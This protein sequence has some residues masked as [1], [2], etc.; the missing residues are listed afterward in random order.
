[1]HFYQNSAKFRTG[2]LADQDGYY[3]S[4]QELL[5]PVHPDSEMFPFGDSRFCVGFD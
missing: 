5:L 1:M 3:H 2:S 4:N